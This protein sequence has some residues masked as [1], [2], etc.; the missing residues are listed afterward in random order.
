[1]HK[2][3]TKVRHGR[4]QLVGSCSQPQR[5]MLV[6]M[7]SP[8]WKLSLGS[9]NRFR[10]TTGGRLTGS[11]TAG[12]VV[13]SPAVQTTQKCSPTTAGRDVSSTVQ[14]APKRSPVTGG[15][16][17][18]SVLAVSKKWPPMP[19]AIP[20]VL[21]QSRRHFPNR[22]QRSPH[23]K[24]RRRQ[25]GGKGLGRRL[26]LKTLPQFKLPPWDART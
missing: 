25:L 13:I 1:M 15:E 12:R 9:A 18:A 17:E 22:P 16:N 4:S 21:F 11:S 7:S 24:V 10:F 2:A 3:A 6:E 23:Q 19:W 14:A 5:P 26:G 20:L 8:P